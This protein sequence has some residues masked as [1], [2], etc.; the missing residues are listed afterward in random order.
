LRRQG[1]K[2]NKALIM[3]IDPGSRS[4]GYGIVET[5]GYSFRYVTS[6]RLVPEAKSP[7]YVRLRDIFEGLN[8]VIGEFSPS[9]A[10]VEKVFFAKSARSALSLGQARGVALLAAANAGLE[11]HEYSALAVKKAVTGYGRAE[12]SQ[13]Q[14]MVKQVLNI[15]TAL[16]SDG[17][18]AL[19]LALCHINSRDYNKA[20]G[21]R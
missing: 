5:D 19:A 17:A 15:K 13:V 8:D 4:L 9:E 1:K 21:A 2:E 14:E 16:S 6:G 11:I 3:G 7:L 10:V 12:K 18:D 20:V